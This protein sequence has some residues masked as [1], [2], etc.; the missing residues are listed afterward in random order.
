VEIVFDN[1]DG[2]F[3][4]GKESTTIRRT[5]GLKKDEYSVDGR[6]ANKTDV[7]NLLQS[8]GFSKSNPYYIVPQ[9]R[10]TALTNAKDEERLALLK[11]VAGTRTYEE[12]RQESLKILT[13]TTTKREKISELLVF[14]EE[15]LS[16]LEEERAELREYQQRDRERRTL[17]YILQHRD[18]LQVGEE[19][20]RLEG[21]NGELVERNVATLEAFD[22]LM[23]QIA[24]FEAELVG[25][26]ENLTQA[27][28]ELKMEEEARTVILQ[29]QTRVKLQ[30]D[31]LR[32]K[33]EKYLVEEQSYQAQLEKVTGD[34]SFKEDALAAIYPRLKEAK[35][36]QSIKQDTLGQLEGRRD[37]LLAKQ[38]RSAQFRS[39]AERDRWIRKEVESMEGTLAL[40]SKQIASLSDELESSQL[41]KKDVGELVVRLSE[42]ESNLMDDLSTLDSQVH[43]LRKRRDQLTEQRKEL[44]RAENKL[45]SSM[46]TLKEEAARCERTLMGATDRGTMQ[47]IEAVKRITSDLRLAGV[48]GPLYELI[49]VDEVYR[50]AAEVIAGSSLFH[51]VVEDENVAGRLLEALVREKAGRV[52]FM[53]LN[54]LRPAA[55]KYPMDR[56]E[57]IPLLPL[58]RFDLRFEVAVKQVFGKAVICRDLA[59]GAVIARQAGLT[60]I[61]LNGDR[62]DRKGALSGGFIDQVSG[63]QC[64]IEYANICI[65]GGSIGNGEQVE[66]MAGQ[67]ARA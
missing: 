14:I 33:K 7:M 3:P 39:A 22:G 16:E 6:T 9:G 58:L 52:T 17:E 37:V 63:S 13:E 29:E 66:N 45:E 31:E 60:A 38:G 25:L 4:T 46:G 42:G 51:V 55:V 5:V 43:G 40:H 49:E 11:E 8:A 2:R 67:T 65:D 30:M 10:V 28:E 35:Q 48:Y 27:E 56:E 1:A 32:I 44:W 64:N 36:Q 34:I 26:R 20:S 59:K 57:A 61:T 50:T 62:A 47:G 41:R 54:R 18:L 24:T 21:E 23:D 12:H 15:R 53:P 19:I